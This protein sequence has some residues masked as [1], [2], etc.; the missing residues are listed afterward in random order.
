MNVKTMVRQGGDTLA[1]GLLIFLALIWGSSF[2]LIKK[3]LLFFGPGQVASLRIVSAG[4]VLVPLS[5]PALRRLKRRHLFLLF[6]IGLVGSTIP[7]FLFAKAQTQLP[8]GITGVLNALTPLFVLI[9]GTLFFGHT[10]KRSNLLGIGVGFAGVVILLLAGAGG[11]LGA[12][13]YYAVYVMLATI[14]YGLNLNIIKSYLADLRPVVITAVSLLFVLPIGAVYLF[15][16]TNFVAVMQ[17]GGGGVWWAL[18]YLCLLGVVGTAIALI[19]FNHLVQ[20]TTPIFTS[21]VT[22]L[23]PIVAVVWGLIDG[24]TLV[25]GQLAGML[26]IIIGV[27]LANRKR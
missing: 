24:E 13:N 6:T 19:L 8:S 2:I 11:N 25:L 16:G 9:L 17:Q 5:L 3:G 1:W 20:I 14:C 12:V 27:W 10:V 7:A 15:A 26:T 22:Y 4:L 21:S 18:L 23:I